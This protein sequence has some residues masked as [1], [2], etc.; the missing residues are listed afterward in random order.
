MKGVRGSGYQG[1]PDPLPLGVLGVRVRQW[2]ATRSI[3]YQY[4]VGK[5]KG[6]QWEGNRQWEGEGQRGVFNYNKINNYSIKVVMMSI[7]GLI[8]IKF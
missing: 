7:A 2:A 8:L 3:G 6:R 5:A 1:H 4:R